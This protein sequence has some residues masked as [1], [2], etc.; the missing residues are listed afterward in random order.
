MVLYDLELRKREIA[1][2]KVFASSAGRIVEMILKKYFN[3]ILIS[4]AIASPLAFYITRMWLQR[5]AFGITI[6]PV[7]YIFSFISVIVIAFLTIGLLSWKNAR[8]NPVGILK[9]N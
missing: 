7:T 8:T 1:I 3:Y 6:S 5:F 4:F 2:R 9:Y